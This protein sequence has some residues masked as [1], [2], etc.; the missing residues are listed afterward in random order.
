MLFGLGWT[1]CIGPT[2]AAVLT[3]AT[4]SAG[5]G[6]GALLSLAYSAGLGVPFIF[7]AFMFH[8][9]VRRFS[10]ARRH[11]RAIMQFGGAMLILLGVLQVTGLWL[12]IIFR[13]QGVI[14]S[15]QMPL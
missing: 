14:S 4:T 3:L 2:L 10:W 6:R 8:R 11:T 12:Q 9:A 5:A 13:L 15:W 1:P 7:A